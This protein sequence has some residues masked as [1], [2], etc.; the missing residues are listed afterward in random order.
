MRLPSRRCRGCADGLRIPMRG[1]EQGARKTHGVP[2]L[3]TNPH[4]GL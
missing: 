1:Y 4:A 2:G 3:V